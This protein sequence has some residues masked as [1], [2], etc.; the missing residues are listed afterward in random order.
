VKRNIFPAPL[1]V[2]LQ[3]SGV[4]SVTGSSSKKPGPS[5][6]L[7]VWLMGV[8]SAM[9]QLNY[10]TDNR[11]VS[12]SGSA[13]VPSEPSVSSNYTASAASAGLFGSFSASFNQSATVQ[14][15]VTNAGINPPGYT[16]ATSQAVSRAAQ[17]SALDP[18]QIT[19][20]SQLYGYGNMDMSQLAGGYA[21]AESSYLQ[22]S[23]YVTSPQNYVISDGLASYLHDYYNSVSGSLS[24]QNHGSLPVYPYVPGAFWNSGT[25]Y[26][27]DTYTLTLSLSGGASG[28]PVDSLVSLED[29]GPGWSLTIVPEPSA[30]TLTGGGAV[31]WLLLRLR[32]PRCGKRACPGAPWAV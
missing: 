24:S 26:P 6:L 17:D 31:V 22:V 1:F 19:F 3:A 20:S 4:K 16:F 5:I 7:L 30:A 9:A 21:H 18:N 32:R 15:W 23:F 8:G 13:F 2:A 12:I 10:L 25:F 11:Y 27:D 29:N 14:G 28:D